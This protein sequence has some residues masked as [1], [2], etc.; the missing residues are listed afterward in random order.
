MG[1]AQHLANITGSRAYEVRSMTRK[2]SAE[3]CDQNQ[4]CHITAD[5]DQLLI[6]KEAVLFSVSKEK[7]YL[8]F[9]KTWKSYSVEI[10]N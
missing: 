1:G 2:S 4:L 5:N 3:S 10:L 7:F 6:I 9:L 8:V